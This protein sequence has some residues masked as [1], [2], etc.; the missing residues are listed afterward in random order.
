MMPQS[1][2]ERTRPQYRRILAHKGKFLDP[3]KAIIFY[4]VI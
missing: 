4:E 1:H 2:T 3:L